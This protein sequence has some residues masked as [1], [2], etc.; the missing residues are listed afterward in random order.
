MDLG[1]FV[2]L[3][4]RD[5]EG[6]PIWATETPYKEGWHYAWTLE[7]GYRV[8]IECVTERTDDHGQQHSE[9]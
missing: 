4:I 6:V 2:K 5:P 7:N 9:E 8:D 1:P 3:A